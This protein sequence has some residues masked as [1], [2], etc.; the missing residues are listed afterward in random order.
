MTWY[1]KEILVYIQKSSFFIDLL[2]LP[3]KAKKINSCK[4]FNLKKTKSLNDFLLEKKSYI[5]RI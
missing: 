1:I 5:T 2:N 3:I 4:Y